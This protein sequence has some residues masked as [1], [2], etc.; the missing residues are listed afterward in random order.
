MTKLGVLGFFNFFLVQWF[1]IRLAFF[2]DDDGKYTSFGVIGFVVPLT[3]WGGSLGP[4]MRQLG[5]WCLQ[6]SRT[7]QLKLPCR[8]KQ[9]SDGSS[10]ILEKASDSP[11]A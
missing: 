8:A 3:G 7:K 9:D 5:G 11:P 2:Y 1:F 10:L 6:F 4:R